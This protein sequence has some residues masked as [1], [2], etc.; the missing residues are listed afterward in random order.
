MRYDN[1]AALAPQNKGDRLWQAGVSGAWG[2]WLLTLALPWFGYVGVTEIRGA[3]ILRQPAAVLGL[4]MVLFAIWCR[5]PRSAARLALG[6]VG[7]GLVL[8][9]V[10]YDLFTLPFGSVRGLQVGPLRFSVPY[11]PHFV[12]SKC[13]DN[14]LPGFYLGA[15]AL[16]LAGGTLLLF[17]RRLRRAR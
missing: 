8:A 17:A 9:A 6:G 14:T 1:G 5:R 11:L 16:P 12:L 4:G 13:L 15:A 7:W 2:L 10:L 3:A